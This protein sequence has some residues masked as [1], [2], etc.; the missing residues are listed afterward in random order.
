[1]K[2]VNFSTFNNMNLSVVCHVCIVIA[3]SV[4]VKLVDCKAQS[5]S[6]GINDTAD[7][8]CSLCREKNNT[9]CILQWCMHGV[10]VRQKRDVNAENPDVIICTE[11]D[12]NSENPGD[13]VRSNV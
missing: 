13:K 8:L 9:T 3:A 10:I 6:T 11:R 5:Q 12:V 4:V 2:V 7:I 1:M